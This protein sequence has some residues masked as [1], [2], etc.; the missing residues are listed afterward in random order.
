MRKSP[1]GIV[2]LITDFGWGGE[3]V[4]AM[5]GAILKVN[6]RCLVTDIT[7]QISPQNILQAAY[8]LQNSY[9]FYPPG[10]VHLAVVDPGV[11]M[12]RRAVALETE[13]HFF[14]GPDNGVFS[15]LLAGKG[16]AE[17]YEIVD[18]KY[19]LRPVS[20]TFHGRDIFAPAAGHL[21]L[22]LPPGKLGPRAENLVRRDFPQPQE[23]KKK[24]GARILWADSFGNLLINVP[25]K[26]FGRALATRPFQIKGK[27]WK[28]ERLSRTY[29]EGKPGQPM[30]LFGS[31]G[32]LEISV[33]QGN[34]LETLGL[35]PGEAISILWG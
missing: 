33:N 11:G 31:G 28:I 20:P 27:G 24:L 35:K 30:A 19:G 6:A 18:R 25:R 22:G 13:G 32:W 29:G 21:S 23:T 17:A 8:V 12:E 15:G 34:A 2:T 26:G 9:R 3:Y 5:K 14:V 10:T 16:K 7:H 4:G 1:P